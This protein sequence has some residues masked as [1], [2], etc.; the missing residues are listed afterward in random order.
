MLCFRFATVYRVL[1]G[2]SGTGFSGN[3]K[4]IIIITTTAAA[5]TTTATASA[6]TTSGL[7]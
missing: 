5:A 7:G 3:D 2:I 4:I 6:T 1:F